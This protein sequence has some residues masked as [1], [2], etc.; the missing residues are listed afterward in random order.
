MKRIPALLLALVLLMMSIP[1]SAEGNTMKFDKTVN[2]VFEGETLQTVLIREGEP[3]EGEVTYES[4][5]PKIATVDEHGVVSGVSK[6]QV[7][8]SA[9]VKTEKKNFRTQLSV[10]VARK[11]TS[12]EVNTD[13]LPVYSASDALVA[14][15]L[16]T[17]ENADEN[18]LPV[19]VLPVK[20][21][22]DL[23]I[24]VM[25]KD[26]TNRRVAV[27]S[28]NPDVVR[29]RESSITGVAP[30]EAI[31]T[32][33]NQLS[34]EV[35]V[36]YRVLTIQPLTRITLTMAEKSVMAGEQ[37]RLVAAVTP[38]NASIPQLIWTSSTPEFATVDQ[39]GTVTGVARGNARIVV[40]AAD[41]SNVRANINVRVTQKAEQIT[42]D[43][44]EMTIDAGRSATLKATVL[45]KNT[46]DKN[47]VW[48]SSDESVA[49][50]NSS[51]RVTAKALGDCEIICTSAV[52][53]E[54]VAKAV[55]HVQQPVTK[56]SFGPEISVYAG[57]TEKVT[58]T[59]EPAD[60]SNP[61][62]TL[63]SSRPKILTVDPDGTVHGLARGEAVVKAQSV[64]GSKRQ[65]QVK[66]RV[67]QH[68]TGVHMKRKT[69][70]IDVK[71]TSSVHALLEP[72]DASNQNVSFSVD[73]PSIATVKSKGN[74]V[75][76]TG[77]SKGETVVRGVT[78]D[79]GFETSI[80]VKIGNWDKALEFK[81][82]T[83]DEKGNFSLRVKNNSDLTITRITAEVRIFDAS[84]DA[85]NAPIPINSKDGSHVVTIVWKK[86]L[87]PGEETSLKKP[88]Q[89]NNYIAPQN[90]DITRGTVSL[91]SFQIDDD[92][93]KTYR[94]TR[95]PSKDW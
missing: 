93:I 43:Q 21:S 36:Q 84:P 69:A 77:V 62:V 74:R 49:T 61:E 51:G 20:K 78:E 73:D 65:A 52:N 44:Q 16:Q 12:V 23:R 94:E 82:F 79:G 7:T 68:V 32:I 64:D 14:G 89:M 2:Q 35:C 60:A 72:E 34:P 76:I 15:L 26:A 40:T 19:I 45:P 58:W 81:G 4:S 8:I 11:A 46:D 56:I 38:E 31:I 18:A 28:D 9:S 13:Q 71:E 86:T 87:L 30:G 80:V 83:W 42:L 66:V 3:A 48:S 22:Y 1:V 95:R 47:V 29:V 25:P 37:I 88:W 75:S 6:G 53:S 92:W 10:T 85:G 24:S 39:D 59:V 91:V 33:A 70:Y 54:A 17:R 55:I 41:G 5:N 67:L 50:V 90:M 63:T 27:T 57:E